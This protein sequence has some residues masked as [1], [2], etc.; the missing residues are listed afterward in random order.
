MAITEKYKAGT[1]VKRKCGDIFKGFG[2]ACGSTHIV[3][4]YLREF[5]RL[6]L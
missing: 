3:R 2:Q 1:G 6:D 5:L 4:L